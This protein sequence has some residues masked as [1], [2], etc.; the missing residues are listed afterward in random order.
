E[1]I[2][3]EHAD[4]VLDWD[5]IALN[6]IRVDKTPPP[7]AS[8]A[9][10]IMSA[11]VY[12]AVNAIAPLHAFY[13]PGAGLTLHPG[14]SLVAAAATAAHDTL[15]SLFPAQAA[16]FDAALAASLAAVPDGPAKDEGVQLGQDVAK[17]M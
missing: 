17:D 12:N 2:D 5:T 15:A 14:A 13:H 7:K 1:P 9:M 8:R 3:P 4:V 10:A 11:S 6:A 16:T